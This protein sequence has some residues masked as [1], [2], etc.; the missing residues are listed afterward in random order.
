MSDNNGLYLGAALLGGAFLLSRSEGGISGG[1]LGETFR[2]QI[3]KVI[4]IPQNV[5]Y[6]ITE[7]IDKT[8]DNLTPDWPDFSGF[9]PDWPDLSTNSMNESGF[10]A[11]T[12]AGG[13][14]GGF[15]GG[16]F[17]GLGSGIVKG[18]MVAGANFAGRSDVNMSNVLSEFS[19]SLG[20][21]KD[22]SLRS[23]YTGVPA[24]AGGLLKGALMGG[25][26]GEAARL[27]SSSS[28]SK[29]SRGGN[30]SLKLNVF[31]ASTPTNAS[32]KPVNSG[33]R[34]ITQTLIKKP[35]EL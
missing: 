32:N 17:L 7:A 1:G 34:V 12:K 28:K 11:G 22:N 35:G 3:E 16:A 26:A 27:L 33:I 18:S 9:W 6:R 5:S 23:V 8:T 19:Q 30:G 15:L 2:E 25:D 14:L 31:K 24:V 21:I 29:S 20:Y 13:G 4:A 10:D